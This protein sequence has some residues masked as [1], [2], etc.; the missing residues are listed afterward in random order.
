M[1]KAIPGKSSLRR[2]SSVMI[3]TAL[4]RIKNRRE[5]GVGGAKEK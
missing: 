5:A 2:S 3:Y 1:R 4:R